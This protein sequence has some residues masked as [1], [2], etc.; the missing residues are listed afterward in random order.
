MDC[1]EAAAGQL[2]K[3]ETTADDDRWDGILDACELTL[4]FPTKTQA[5]SS[6]V[7]TAAGGVVFRLPVAGRPP[8]K[9]FW[10]LNESGAARIEAVFEHD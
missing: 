8:M 3:L 6:A 9:A 10:S 4:N 5:L 7:R 2:D 1:S